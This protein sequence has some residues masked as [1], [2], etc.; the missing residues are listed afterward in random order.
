MSSLFKKNSLCAPGER[1]IQQI[2]KLIIL[3]KGMQER[4]K[5]IMSQ[6]TDWATQDGQDLSSIQQILINVVNGITALDTLITQFQMSPGT[7]SASDQA[8]LDGIQVQVKSLL[9][10]SANISTAIP[11]AP[12]A[13]VISSTNPIIP[14]NPPVPSNVVVGTNASGQPINTA[15][16]VIPAIPN[17]QNISNPNINNPSAPNLSGVP[18]VPGSQIKIS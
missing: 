4:N 9:A 17:A 1:Q 11:T 2:N 16:Q 10:Q 6:I 15:G 13:N 8:A 5:N 18:V 7:L 14:S 3:I 12:T